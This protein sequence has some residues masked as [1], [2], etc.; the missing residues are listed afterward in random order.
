MK[1][2]GCEDSTLQV[3]NIFSFHVNKKRADF[4]LEKPYCTFNFK[5]F[6]Q[7]LASR[8]NTLFK[9]VNVKMVEKKIT[10]LFIPMIENLLQKF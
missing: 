9:I 1:E 4:Y 5:K 8:T 10:L 7:I 2:I 3:P 6:C